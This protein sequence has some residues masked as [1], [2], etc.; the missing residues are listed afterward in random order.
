[1]GNESPRILRGAIVLENNL[2]GDYATTNLATVST[3]NGKMIT[4]NN[5]LAPACTVAPGAEIDGQQTF[6]LDQDGYLYVWGP[7]YLP[8]MGPDAVKARTVCAEELPVVLGGELV[9][10]AKISVLSCREARRCTRLFG[11]V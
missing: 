5:E 2:A 11:C 10:H 8:D 3:N 1:M 6:G 9:Y 4:A 7:R